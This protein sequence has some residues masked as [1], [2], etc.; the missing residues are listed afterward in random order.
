MPPGTLFPRPYA[1]SHECEGEGRVKATTLAA[2]GVVAAL[3]AG[4]GDG[5]GSSAAKSGVSETPAGSPSS[6]TTGGSAAP[7]S[8]HAA[9]VA[10][11][12]AMLTISDFPSGWS[13]S[14]SGGSGGFGS[15]SMFNRTMDSC[16]HA[17]RNPFAHNP[18]E[19]ETDSP[20]FDSPNGGDRS[21]DESID[22]AAPATMSEDFHVFHLPRFTHCLTEAVQPIFKAALGKQAARHHVTL[23]HTTIGQLSVPAVGQDTVGLRMMVPMSVEGVISIPLYIDMVFARDGGSGVEMS[24]MSVAKPF[25]ASMAAD[26]MTRAYQKLDRANTARA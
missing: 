15:Q 5:S 18:D 23:G 17:P 22:S 16:L 11:R 9:R 12:S 26:L 14:S 21:V 1:G 7:F 10:D 2:L 13:T 20:D 4:C 6:G 3:A 24:F 8:A 19:V 25:P